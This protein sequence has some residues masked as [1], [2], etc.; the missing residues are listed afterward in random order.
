[1]RAPPS[2]IFH[3]YKVIAAPVKRSPLSH[4]LS[5]V[6][7]CRRFVSLQMVIANT[8]F[9]T[10]CY[11]PDEYQIITSGTNRKVSLQCF[12]YST[13]GRHSD[14]TNLSLYLC[15]EICLG[16]FCT[17]ALELVELLAQQV[18]PHSRK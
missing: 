14:L 3:I 5:S 11:H 7:S 8:L 9:R 6:S 15:F 4:L 17:L 1:M 2:H 10:V 16:W 12:T 18:M 13:Q